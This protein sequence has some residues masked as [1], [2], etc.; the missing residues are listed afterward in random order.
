MLFHKQGLLS[1]FTQDIDWATD[2]VKAIVLTE[3][4]YNPT[5]TVVSDVTST[6]LTG[7]TRPTIPSRSTIYNDADDQVELRGDDVTIASVE[8]GQTIET[9]ILYKEVTDDTDSIL[10]GYQSGLSQLTNGGGITLDL[11]PN[12]NAVDN[13][14]LFA[15]PRLPQI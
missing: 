10:I 6:E 7:Y 1:I 14:Y 5:H 11:P 13:N 12:D 3:Y 15:F 2:T 8:S 9:V 4:T